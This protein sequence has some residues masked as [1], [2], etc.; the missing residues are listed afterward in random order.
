MGKLVAVSAAL[1]VLIAAGG[2]EP[3]SF[4]DGERLVVEGTVNL[5][6]NEPFARLALRAAD[7]KVFFLPPQMDDRRREL[8]NRTVRIE[9]TVRVTVLL[10]ADRRHKVTEYRLEDAR[11][12]GP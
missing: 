4:G 11:V 1:I 8:L 9:G 2:R 6:G 5:V 7:G 3:G 12:V 10:S